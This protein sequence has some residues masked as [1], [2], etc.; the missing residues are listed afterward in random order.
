MDEVVLVVGP[1]RERS[2]EAMERREHL[3]EVPGVGDV[4]LMARHDRLWRDRTDVPDHDGSEFTL[5][6]Q[7]EEFESVDDEILMLAKTDRRPPPRPTVLRLPG[8]EAE[9]EDSDDNGGAARRHRHK[10]KQRSQEIEIPMGGGWSPRPC[11]DGSIVFSMT[12][13]FLCK[14]EG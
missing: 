5:R 2:G 13:G 4:D 7:M 10:N 12:C 9:A 1:E 3:L 11:V 8:V 14:A 6:R